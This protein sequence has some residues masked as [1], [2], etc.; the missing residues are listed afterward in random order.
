M[1]KEV[2]LAD[3]GRK[4]N[5]STVTVSK[6]LSG[7][8]GVS[9]QKRTQILETARKMGYD[10]IIRKKEESV[11]HTIGVIVASRYLE[12]KH[13]FYWRFYQEL[14]RCATSRKSFSLLEIVDY[15]M[16]KNRT[17]PKLVSERKA[18]GIIVLGNFSREY[19]HFLYEHINLPI[20]YLDSLEMS[21]RCDCVVTD[22]MIGG[23]RMTNYLYGLGHEKIGFVGT[24]RATNS[25]DDRYFGYL[26]SLL[27]HGKTQ[28]EDWILQDRSREN[29]IIDQQ[30]F[31]MP[32]KGGPTAYFCN[33]D[34]TASCFISWLTG[35]DIR[36]PEDISVVGFDNYLPDD[37]GK[38]ALTTYDINLH[39]M[40]GSAISLMIHK[41]EQTRYTS[42]IIMI[43][44]KFIERSSAVRI[45]DPVRQA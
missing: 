30:F 23:Y 44:G 16:E 1:A 45:A 20:L 22:N 34:L 43:Q 32:S 40:A 28:K 10:R 18:E 36:V 2:T 4:L 42:G 33:S 3:I 6:A 14:A 15:H 9:E 41:I 7:S 38:V 19:M 29:G 35:Q 31:H 17:I 12:E 25:I 13:S 26:K 8:K 39:Q 37:V 11:L 21:D 24:L 5:V 27:E